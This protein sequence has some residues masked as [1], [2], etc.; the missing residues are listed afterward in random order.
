MAS[1]GG[2]DYFWLRT[3]ETNFTYNSYQGWKRAFGTLYQDS[4]GQMYTVY[5]DR[6]SGRQVLSW[7][8]DCTSFIKNGFASTNLQFTQ[9][10]ED[11]LF[12]MM[13]SP[14][15]GELF[16]GYGHDSNPSGPGQG[17]LKVSGAN[18]ANAT[19]DEDWSFPN[20][21]TYG[22]YQIAAP[23]YDSSG[24]MYQFNDCSGYYSSRHTLVK[25]NASGTIQWMAHPYINNNS[26]YGID[27]PKTIWK[28]SNGDVYVATR[29]HLFVFDD[30]NGTLS[31][32]YK[33]N[34]TP[35]TQ[36]GHPVVSADGDT[37]YWWGTYYYSYHPTSAYRG[38]R[39][40]YTKVDCSSSVPS[41]SWSTDSYRFNNGYM[42]G[43]NQMRINSDGGLTV[44]A[45]YRDST[46][47]SA[48][49]I[50]IFRITNSGV[51]DTTWKIQMSDDDYYAQYNVYYGS[52]TGSQASQSITMDENLPIWLSF[53]YNPDGSWGFSEYHSTVLLKLP[54]DWWSSISAGTYGDLTFATVYPWTTN[55]QYGGCSTYFPQNLVNESS[56]YTSNTRTNFVFGGP[57]KD[58]SGSQ[59]SPQTSEPITLYND[60]T[61]GRESF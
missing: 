42:Q 19:V 25:Y 13:E 53:N 11:C 7:D 45:N 6:L 38:Y 50:Y 35:P 32:V 18:A 29:T 40:I 33:F 46:S 1:A 54:A 41:E 2:E 4:T 59:R 27:E 3:N 60:N 49:G 47:S 48:N 15:D 5:S 8:P 21:T 52:V 43:G 30:S 10:N 14:S 58:E 20:S 55:C 22:G 51:M 61:K 9:Y 56:N 23:Y 44:L 39:D 24:N 16:I 17:V 26:S 36:K 57:M 12:G 37:V 31:Y 34:Q 28:N